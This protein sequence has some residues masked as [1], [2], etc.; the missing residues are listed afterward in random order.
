M[1]VS[2]TPTL[3]KKQKNLLVVRL[4][5]KTEL[6]LVQRNLIGIRSVRLL[7]YNFEARAP[8]ASHRRPPVV[9][10][11]RSA[12]REI[13][14]IGM[15]VMSQENGVS[16]PNCRATLACSRMNVSVRFFRAS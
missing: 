12:D 14:I 8:I 3:V 2:N 7:H 16:M 9:G 13:P 11:L 1:I 6:R 15:F 10:Y 5:A 4:P